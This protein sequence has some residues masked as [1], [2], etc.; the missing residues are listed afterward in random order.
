[1]RHTAPTKVRNVLV[2]YGFLKP[3]QQTLRHFKAVGWTPRSSCWGTKIKS[4][5]ISRSRFRNISFRDAE[6]LK[7][8]VFDSYFDGCDFSSSLISKSYFV[9]VH[10]HRCDFKSANISFTHFDRCTFSECTFL[11]TT[12]SHTEISGPLASGTFQGANVF[13]ARL[14]SEHLKHFLSEGLSLVGCE[15]WSQKIFD[16]DL[17]GVDLRGARIL[18]CEISNCSFRGADL[19][20]TEFS[21]ADWR[22]LLG[23]REVFVSR[24]SGCDFQE[25]RV[26]GVYAC[27]VDFSSCRLDAGATDLMIL[28]RF[29]SFERDGLK[30][31]GV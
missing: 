18:N 6:L 21:A 29:W 17:D 12:I 8:S 11:G 31:Y 22:V 15:L 5:S 7:T 19:R 20:D 4:G 27:D 3:H 16:I 9:E 23:R 1:V 13:G 28:D 14:R 26:Q 10:F 30:D 2:R 25:A 24:F